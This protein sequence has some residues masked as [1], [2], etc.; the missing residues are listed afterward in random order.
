[1]CADFLEKNYDRVSSVYIYIFESLSKKK[2]RKAVAEFNLTS[3][4]LR[5]GFHR[6]RE[7]P[8]FW[9]LCHQTAVFE[10]WKLSFSNLRHARLCL[11]VQAK[12]FALAYLHVLRWT[13]PCVSS[14]NC[15]QLLGE[16]LLDR[17]N[18]T[19]MTKYISK[20]ENLKLMM[21]MLRDKSRNIQFEAFHVFKVS[22]QENVHSLSSATNIRFYFIYFL[23]IRII[24][25]LF[26]A[27]NLMFLYWPG[28]RGK[29]QQDSAC[30]GHT[31]E[32]PGQTGGVPEPLPDWPVG[33][34][35]VLWREEL[36]DKTNPGPQE[37]GGTRGSLKGNWKQ[38]GTA[39][40]FRF[41]KT[42]KKKR[43]YNI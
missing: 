37:G 19:V 40:L 13:G 9:K 32:E 16:L 30:D 34:R 7:A 14:P 35:A 26:I 25:L 27:S 42:K 38:M 2:K 36:S 21:N 43:N 28:V 4:H 23:N 10:G 5:T 15:F 6:V 20:A 22:A 33:G 3:S 12:R 24:Y 11:Y 29:P 17:H 41:K 8:A 31:A 1:M 18:F 39:G